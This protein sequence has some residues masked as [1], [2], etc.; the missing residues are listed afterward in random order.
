VVVR[1]Q[2]A[3]GGVSNFSFLVTTDGPSKPL[4]YQRP[5]GCTLLSAAESIPVF[6]YMLYD[7]KSIARGPVDSESPDHLYAYFTTP[8]SDGLEL[9]E[10]RWDEVGRLLGAEAEPL[11]RAWVGFLRSH[12][13][14]YLH[15]ETYEYYQLADS[16]ES[17]ERDLR[18]C[19]AAFDHVPR[20]VTA[21][22]YPNRW[23]RALLGQAHVREGDGRFRT[24]GNRSY[25]GDRVFGYPVPW[26]V[27]EGVPCG[28]LAGGDSQ[29]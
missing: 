9:A 21:G 13:R 26:S 5:K 27:S 12:A 25:A 15:C 28:T 16:D 19:L 20:R 6:W 18:I 23:W 2:K 29:S 24:L 17:H 8:T 1:P 4:H 22:V 11:F 3:E 7:E 10:R 14:G